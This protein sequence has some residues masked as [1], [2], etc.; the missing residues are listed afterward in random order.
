MYKVFVNERPLIFTNNKDAVVKKS[1]S[2]SD[3]LDFKALVAQLFDGQ[4]V[5]L[6]IYHPDLK[7][8]WASFKSNFK[9]EKAAGGL[10]YNDKE[11]LLF[12]HRLDK[13]D[14]PKGHIEKG[15]SKK[16]AAIREVE[17]ECGISG[18]E[19]IEKLPISY[20]MFIRKGKMVLKITHWYRMYS[21]YKGGLVPQ[22]NEGID[23]V[24]FKSKIAQGEVLKNTYKNIA[25]LLKT[26]ECIIKP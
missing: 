12:I 7:E 21:V 19:I 20:H 13:W 26:S 8:M 4:F 6:Q 17:E 2:Y 18:L 24:C 3:S 5:S 10:V 25:L 23:L 1:L 11:E 16:E 15:E 22:T 9:I 14:L